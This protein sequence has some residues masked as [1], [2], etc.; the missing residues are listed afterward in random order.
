MN[1]CLYIASINLLFVNWVFEA[2]CVTYFLRFFYFKVS[3][4]FLP[5][6]TLLQSPVDTSL[7]SKLSLTIVWGPTSFEVTC[8]LDSLLRGASYFMAGYLLFPLHLRFYRNMWVLAIFYIQRESGSCDN[9]DVSYKLATLFYS[10][11]YLLSLPI[12]DKH[13]LDRR[14]YIYALCIVGFMINNNHPCPR[15]PPP[16]SQVDLIHTLSFIIPRLIGPLKEHWSFDSILIP[17]PNASI[18]TFIS[19]VANMLGFPYTER[20][21][22]RKLWNDVSYKLAAL[23]Y[24]ANYLVSLPITKQG[25]IDRRINIYAYA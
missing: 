20:F 19:T 12:T 17:V 16:C 5:P 21:Y 14:I 10:A 24:S 11:N 22:L 7:W 9:Y 3:C 1:L 4:L 2:T 13:Q 18:F 25:P 15:A 23:V 8:P 6:N